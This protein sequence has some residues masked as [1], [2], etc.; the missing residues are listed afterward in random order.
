MRFDRSWYGCI[1]GFVFAVIVLCAQPVLA[2]PTD[3]IDNGER[4]A[5]CGMFV[6]K[7][8]NW[9]T[10]L[11]YSDGAVKFFDGVKDMMVHYFD[12]ASFG[13]H[14]HPDVKEVWVKDYYTL[15][16]IDGRDAYFVVGS[17]VNGPMGHEFIPFESKE[18]AES[19][20]KDH[21]GK[22]ILRFGDI[23]TE[24]VESMRMGHKM[25]KHKMDHMTK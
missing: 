10:Q 2:E 16:W 15:K 4:C 5:V 13:M 9:V 21:Q 24:K 17:D 1:V 20:K 8:P 18:A 14:G 19:F 12:P 11:Q 22:E 25:K 23:S 7:Y 3:H 6:A